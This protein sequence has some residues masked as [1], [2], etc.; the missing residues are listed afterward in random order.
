MKLNMLRGMLAALL[1][2]ASAA[3]AGTPLPAP[4]IGDT[5]EI[6][7]TRDSAQQGNN[8]SSGSTHD[9]DMIIERI[10]GLRR[11][12]LE[13][14]YDLP[15][16][17]TAEERAREWQFPAEVFEP[18]GGP[19]QLLNGSELEARIDS[20]LKAASLSRAACGHWIFTWNAFRIECDPQSVLKTVKSYDL[21]SVDL[22]EGAAYQDSEASSPGRLARKVG[23]IEGE[24][25]AAEMPVDSDTVRRARAESDVV[26]GEIMKRPVSLEA[27]LH[28]HAVEIV[29][30]TISVVF[31]TDPDGKVRR[32]T[33]V[34]KLDIKRPDGRKETQSVTETLERRLISRRD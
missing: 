15:N 26:V 16:T 20:W 17:A 33:K 6:T 18:F 23:G 5:Y 8:G 7:L 9:K 32:R 27:A 28:E 34:T 11:D 22:H 3:H 30:G 13:L 21:R 25:F 12:G 31:D 29:S 4:Q 24:T 2:P 19:A 14:Q 10:T 1:L